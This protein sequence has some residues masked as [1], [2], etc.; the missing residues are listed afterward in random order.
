MLTKFDQ[1]DVLVQLDKFLSFC[2]DQKVDDEII[3]DV[4]IKTL[5]YI[6]KCSK[7]KTPRN[8]QMTKKYLQVLKSKD[9]QAKERYKL[10]LS[11]T[12]VN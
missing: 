3:T 9:L 4:N 12:S 8:I 7:Q 10:I 11:W 2:K 1:N 6:K 5:N